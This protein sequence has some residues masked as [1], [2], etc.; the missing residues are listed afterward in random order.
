MRDMKLTTRTV[1]AAKFD[2]KPRKLYDGHGLYLHVTSTSKT[3]RYGYRIGGK[4]K[5]FT[6]GPADL[7][8]LAQ[9]R[10]AHKEA[11]REVL[12][13]NDPVAVRRD[14]RRTQSTPTMGQLMDD[15]FDRKRHTIASADKME[16]RLRHLRPA[17]RAKLVTELTASDVLDEM[18]AIHKRRSADMAHR[19]LSYVRTALDEVVEDD[20]IPG[21]G[22]GSNPATSPKVRLKMP[23]REQ[24]TPY[25][26]ITDVETMG[27]VLR[28]IDTYS[29]ENTTSAAMWLLPRLFCRPSELRELQ[30][31]EV[32]LAD[33]QLE[34]TRGRMKSR[35]EFIIPLADQCF[36]VIKAL[37]DDRR[38][39]VVFY[40]P[41]DKKRP[42]S[43]M[44]LST[45]LVRI[46]ISKDTV[47]PHGFRHTA[48]T[49]L[50]ERQFNVDGEMV[51]F[52]PDVIEAQLA[53]QRSDV[54][55]RYNRAEYID[56]R[57]I[58]MQAY[59]DWL[60]DIKRQT[61]AN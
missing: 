31:S 6:I 53:H 50:N 7:V 1:A 40:S 51:R 22:I 43:N 46:G 21:G 61:V 41:L 60:D 25:A 10:D 35:R 58:M 59:A 13:G 3:W 54:R 32:N 57:R 42:F 29:G 27:Q 39:D 45:G 19:V 26:H 36:D 55:S 20:S 5:T 11:R 4:Q 24:E 34:I 30:W 56:E 16:S 49:F 9:A 23:V 2:G 8:T 12:A 28:A 52:R 37:H 17:F 18:Q 33:R 47:V 38:S 44:T 14:E 48:S 15:W